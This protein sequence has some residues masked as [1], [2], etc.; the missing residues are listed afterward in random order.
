[1]LSKWEMVYLLEGLYLLNATPQDR[2]PPNALSF[3]ANLPKRL[4]FPLIKVI[5]IETDGFTERHY[6]KCIM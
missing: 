2:G 5:K 6:L 3:L 1:M 4:F